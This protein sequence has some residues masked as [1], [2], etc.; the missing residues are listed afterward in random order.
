VSGQTVYTYVGNDPLNGTDP[1]G[2]TGCKSEGG[3]TVC[4]VQVTG[5]HI[6]QKVSAEN[7]GKVAGHTSTA[8]EG[9][10][11]AGESKLLGKAGEKVVAGAKIL[12]PVADA[13][14]VGAAA[15]EVHEANARG[16]SEKAAAILIGKAISTA[17]KPVGGALG[18]YLG[19]KYLDSPRFGAFLGKELT[20]Y[21]LDSHFVQGPI[22][23]AVS[24]AL[25]NAAQAGIDSAAPTMSIGDAIN[26]LQR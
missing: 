4:D 5:S 6:P 9:A 8:A 18:A 19:Q 22:A 23:T 21:V 2:D 25:N 24:H 16:D 13:V 17:A 11:L 26:T 7:V 15:V 1:S 3:T 12:A 20:G 14:E 10:K